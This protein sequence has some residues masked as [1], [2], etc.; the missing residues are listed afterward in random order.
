MRVWCPPQE[1]G[2]LKG[3][4]GATSR[5]ALFKGAAVVEFILLLVVVALLSGAWGWGKEYLESKASDGTASARTVA[6]M[7]TMEKVA[8]GLLWLLERARALMQIALGL[9]LI[10]FF[11]EMSFLGGLDMG[12]I[13]ASGALVLFGIW[14]LFT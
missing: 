9:F 11:N 6:G 2:T 12:A 8:E 7:N 4:C 10:Y 13:V 1:S 5:P 3:E 14:D